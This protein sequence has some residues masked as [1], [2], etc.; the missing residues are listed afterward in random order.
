MD[1]EEIKVAQMASEGKLESATILLQAYIN[2]QKKILGYETLSTICN[3][4]KGNITSMES[5]GVTEDILGNVAK[6]VY[7]AKRIDIKELTELKD[8]LKGKMKREDFEEAKRGGNV[9]K[10]F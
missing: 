5:H 10:T 1:K 3:Q 9:D 2:N 4:L 7:A 6:L 8:I